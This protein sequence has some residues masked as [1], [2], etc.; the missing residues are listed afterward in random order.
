MIPLLFIE[1]QSTTAIVGIEDTFYA[2]FNTPENSIAGSAVCSFSL[3]DLTTTFEERGPLVPEFV[4]PSRVVFAHAR[5]A[6]EDGLEEVEE[7]E[8]GWIV[9]RAH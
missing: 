8:E 3:S 6:G 9:A 2:V 7:G 1:I 5:H 4:R